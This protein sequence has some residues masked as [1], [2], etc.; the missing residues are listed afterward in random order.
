M[1]LQQLYGL[2]LKVETTRNFIDFDS[3]FH[4]LSTVYAQITHAD[5]LARR[6][7]DS[8]FTVE[9]PAYTRTLRRYS[10]RYQLNPF[11]VL[12]TMLAFLRCF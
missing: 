2:P 10:P 6:R 4:R 12:E 7:L 11:G 1:S 3:L 9:P 5:S 8:L